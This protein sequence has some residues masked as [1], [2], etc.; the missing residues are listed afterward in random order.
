MNMKTKENENIEKKLNNI[1]NDIQEVTKNLKTLEAD[2]EQYEKDSKISKDSES[3]FI[4]KFNISEADAG[5]FRCFE[6]IR[7][8]DK[9]IKVAF[10]DS[11]DDYKNL[12]R[13][14]KEE[15]EVLEERIEEK[16]NE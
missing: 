3:E 13:K 12:L 2:Y 16:S 10:E 14:I 4:N 15:K 7:R 1:E 9:Q 11:K 6:E 8:L 5:I